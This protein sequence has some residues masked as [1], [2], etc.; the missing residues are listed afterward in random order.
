MNL[1]K[2]LILEINECSEVD[3][4]ILKTES[5]QNEWVQWFSKI[6]YYMTYTCLM[7]YM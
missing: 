7:L 5:M 2:R 6:L 3:I 1:C 4:E